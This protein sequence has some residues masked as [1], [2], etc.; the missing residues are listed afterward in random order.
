M[1]LRILFVRTAMYFQIFFSS[2]SNTETIPDCPNAVYESL[3]DGFPFAVTG[4]AG[5][6]AGRWIQT[7]VDGT[8]CPSTRQR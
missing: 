4:R 8:I 5:K 3:S 7:G 6:K 1:L 2:R